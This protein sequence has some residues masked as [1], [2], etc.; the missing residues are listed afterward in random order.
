MN[1]ISNILPSNARVK[2]VDLA[3]S[4]PIRPGIPEFGRPSGSTATMRDRVTFSQQARELLQNQAP[5]RRPHEL[6]KTKLAQSISDQFFTSRLEPV[7]VP[8]EFQTALPVEVGLDSESLLSEVDFDAQEPS[9]DEAADTVA[10][11][12][13]DTVATDAATVRPRTL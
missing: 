5:A 4:H 6:S 2:S 9:L 13:A 12:L 1:K 8:R 7:K 3:A 11:A 10:T